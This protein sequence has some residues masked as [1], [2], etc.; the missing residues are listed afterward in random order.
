MRDFGCSVPFPGHEIFHPE[1]ST[2]LAFNTMIISSLPDH[3]LSKT[4]GGIDH[5]LDQSGQ[6]DTVD[7]Q[8]S[9]STKTDVQEKVQ[10]WRLGN[11][12]TNG[13]QDEFLIK[14]LK[15]TFFVRARGDAMTGAYIQDGDLLIVDRSIEPEN[16]KV[17]IAI[18]NGEFIIRRLR[19]H[20][21]V[22][23]L[24]AENADYPTIP[25]TDVPPVEIW[26]VVTSKWHSFH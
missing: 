20:N 19:I 18:M 10:Q 12:K 21:G 5:C 17:V 11:A 1:P 14:N 13:N 6:P 9:E 7:P 25:V 22:S 15:D 2:I 8:T 16:K 4:R 26:G 3:L 23:T 24:E